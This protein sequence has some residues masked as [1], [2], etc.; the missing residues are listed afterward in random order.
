M[1]KQ[2]NENEIKFALEK[3]IIT[4]LEAREMLMVYLHKEK[5]TPVIHKSIILHQVA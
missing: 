3:G 2:L 5:F 4:S 1:K